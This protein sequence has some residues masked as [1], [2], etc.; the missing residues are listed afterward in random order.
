MC[1][2]VVTTTENS[3]FASRLEED[4]WLFYKSINN[5]S[6]THL[7][8]CSLGNVVYFPRDEKAEA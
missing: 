8:S 2:G 4:I 6:G 7:S 3:W 5:G 1:C